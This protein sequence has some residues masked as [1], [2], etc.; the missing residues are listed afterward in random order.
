VTRHDSGPPGRLI[1][2]VGQE[3]DRDA[4]CIDFTLQASRLLEA[5]CRRNRWHQQESRLELRWPNAATTSG[6]L[7]DSRLRQ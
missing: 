4:G 2:D 1:I 7:D 6:H 5:S 3:S